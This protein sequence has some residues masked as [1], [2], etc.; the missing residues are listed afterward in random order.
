[1]RYSESH[2]SRVNCKFTKYGFAIIEKRKK[3]IIKDRV[4]QNMLQKAKEIEEIV[5]NRLDAL[6]IPCRNIDKKVMKQV[7]NGSKQCNFKFKEV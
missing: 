7:V 1:M 3:R 6:S 2:L 5:C 4:I